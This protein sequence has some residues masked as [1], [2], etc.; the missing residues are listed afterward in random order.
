MSAHGLVTCIF[1]ICM[2][3]SQLKVEK[4]L[5][6]RIDVKFQITLHLIKNELNC[7]RYTRNHFLMNRISLA[8]F[9][10]AIIAGYSM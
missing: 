8:R 7:L 9:A 6:N 1:S 4:N 3:Y 5:K 2:I 10:Q